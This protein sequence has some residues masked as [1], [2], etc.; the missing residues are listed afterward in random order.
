MSEAS[1][2]GVSEAAGVSSTIEV[3]MRSS[4]SSRKQTFFGRGKSNFDVREEV[5]ETSLRGS[6]LLR[7]MLR[8]PRGREY[9]VEEGNG[10]V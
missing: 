4:S 2:Y 10:E 6:G 9:G 3:G 1:E 8:G 5:A 7:R